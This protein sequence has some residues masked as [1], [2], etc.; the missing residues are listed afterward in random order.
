M[1]TTSGKDNNEGKED[2]SKDNGDNA[3]DNWQGR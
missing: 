2:N 3:K 1:V